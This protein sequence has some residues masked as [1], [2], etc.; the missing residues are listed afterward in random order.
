MQTSRNRWFFRGS[1]V[2]VVLLALLG[3]YKVA[4]YDSTGGLSVATVDAGDW[5]KGTP[6]KPVL[7]EYSDFQCPACGAYY[8]IVKAVAS[9]FS[10]RVQFVYRH[11]PLSTIHKNA[12]AGS[13]AAEAA[14]KQGKFWEMHDKL[15]ERQKEW[16]VGEAPNVLLE[17]YA[18]E[19]GLDLEKF[20]QDRD[21]T[22][23]RDR[24]AASYSSG[25]AA[26]VQGTPTFFFN[27]KRIQSPGSYEAFRAV[28]QY[29][30]NQISNPTK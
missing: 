18:Q 15:F 13:Y 27:G 12:L 1:I 8:P 17:K 7:I 21:S 3:I 22:E 5:T 9:E 10:G 16:S 20:K 24:V 29:Q 28:L 25:E 2:L 23:V 26:G 30:L 14:G 6:G 19:L 11:F 4:T